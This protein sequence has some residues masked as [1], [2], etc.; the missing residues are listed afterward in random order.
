MECH[1]YN[2][3]EWKNILNKIADLITNILIN[4]KLLAPR[5]TSQWSDFDYKLRCL[6]FNGSL[7]IIM[8]IIS[9]L[10][11]ITS[12]IFCLIVV[13]N[14]LRVFI[15]GIHAQSLRYCFI[16]SNIYF[17]SLALLSKYII[18]NMNFRI[19]I[20][21][22]ISILIWSIYNYK[23]IPR[24]NING[25]NQL[26]NNNN[27]NSNEEDLTIAEKK[28]GYRIIIYTICAIFICSSIFFIYNNFIGMN[29]IIG[30]LSVNIILNKY[31]EKI[32]MCFEKILTK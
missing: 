20:V 27:N 11:N 26:D 15:D 13:F 10:L 5:G 22:G 32:F 19:Q 30:L 7:L 4:K 28:K 31:F 9:V 21:I 6:I 25:L 23:N 8:L 29:L 24:Y 14:V 3:K 18:N 1:I 16:F 12:E 17:I 2:I